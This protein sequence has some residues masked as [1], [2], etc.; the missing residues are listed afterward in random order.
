MATP[1]SI[2]DLEGAVNA[3]RGEI[4]SI[5]APQIAAS[6]TS[7]RSEIDRTVMAALAELRSHSE[8]IAQKVSTAVEEKFQSASAAFTAEQE[9][10]R[11]QL[12]SGQ[13]R[14]TATEEI[15]EQTL[16]KL[17]GELKTTVE[18]LATVSDGKLDTVATK[19][20]AQEALL[21]EF[22][23]DHAKNIQV[24]HTIMSSEVRDMHGNVTQ[25][26]STLNQRMGQIEHIVQQQMMNA[27]V[28]GRQAPGGARGY[29][30][31]VPDP[32]SWNLTILKNG[33]TGFL[34]WRKSFELQVRAIWA[35][36]DVVLEALRDEALPI[37]RAVYE[38]LVQ[39][40]MPDGASPMDW[41]YIH[42]SNKL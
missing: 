15:F 41:D 30:I 40:H 33:E 32:K 1:A 18:K 17:D 27:P 36:L 16:T 23:A 13:D 2:Q 34:P 20:I 22:K 19:L 31:R 6:T 10:M 28:D 12:Q 37:G 35:G 11:G 4:T 24:V 29:Q 39:P 42:I 5:V 8:G 3:L 26:G 7:L 14:I 38:R 21:E 9:L 25:L